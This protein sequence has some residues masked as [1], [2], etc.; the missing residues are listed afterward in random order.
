VTPQGEIPA[1]GNGLD[2]P[3]AD[4]F[5]LGDDKFVE[6]RV[7]WHQAAMMAQLSPAPP[8]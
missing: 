2:V 6:H 8:S 3:F 4:F 1:S 5:R 7:Y